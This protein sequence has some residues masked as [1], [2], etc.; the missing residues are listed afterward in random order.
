MAKGQS[1]LSEE[2]KTP[3]GPIRHLNVV[4]T[5]SDEDQN[6]LVEMLKGLLK[7]LIVKKEDMAQKYVQD[8]QRGAETSPYLPEEFYHFFEFFLRGAE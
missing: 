4:I 8:M 5:E 3:K 6:Y 2:E 1:F 7:G